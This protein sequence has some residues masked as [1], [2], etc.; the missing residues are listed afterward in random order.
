MDNGRALIAK[1]CA[2][3]DAHINLGKEAKKI[4]KAKGDRPG[5][6]GSPG[7]TGLPT[8]EGAGAEEAY[9]LTAQ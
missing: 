5:K 2:I 9:R 3:L 7:G 8:L 1:E 6:T 4:Q